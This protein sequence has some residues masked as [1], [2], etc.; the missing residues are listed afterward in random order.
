MSDSSEFS[1]AVRKL[2]PQVSCF[3]NGALCPWCG[4]LH[5][6]IT[7]GGNNC[8]NCAK[9]FQFGY[10]EWHEGKDP[11][12][13]VPFPFREFE[14]LGGRADLLPDWKPNHAIK[15]ARHEKV[16]EATGIYAD[17]SMPQ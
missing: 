9:F 8:L 10:P 12:S 7:F 2:P 15:Q 13:W 14:A 1:K 4:W 16:E 3:A 17:R 6:T 11:V 5:A